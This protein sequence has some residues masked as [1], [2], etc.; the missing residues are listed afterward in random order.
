MLLRNGETG[1]YFQTPDKWTTAP[2]CAL[3]FESSAHAIKT[4]IEL[5]LQNMEIVLSFGNPAYD[6][7]LP[8]ANDHRP[9]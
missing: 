6:V 1:L 2:Q 7:M 9:F 8:V 5:R 4:V 3:V